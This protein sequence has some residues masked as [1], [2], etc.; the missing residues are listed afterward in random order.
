[1]RIITEKDKRGLLIAFRVF[2]RTMTGERISQQAGDVILGKALDEGLS[3]DVLLNPGNWARALE[4]N[5]E[6]TA[7][8]YIDILTE[9]KIDIRPLKEE[10]LWHIPE[11]GFTII[12]EAAHDFFMEVTGRGGKW[13]IPSALTNLAKCIQLHS[14]EA[15]L[16]E[17][18]MNRVCSK[19][20]DITYFGYILAI[21]KDFNSLSIETG[22]TEAEQ[23]RLA[24]KAGR[25]E[26]SPEEKKDNANKEEEPEEHQEPEVEEYLDPADDPYPEMGQEFQQGTFETSFIAQANP[27]DM[28][29][30]CLK[31]V[32]ENYT[33]Y[34]LMGLVQTVEGGETKTVSEIIDCLTDGNFDVTKE[35]ADARSIHQNISADLTPSFIDCVRLQ[36]V[37][38]DEAIASQYDILHDRWDLRTA[39]T[40][41]LH[42]LK[43]LILTY[44]IDDPDLNSAI[45]DIE[46][47][48]KDKEQ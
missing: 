44:G 5:P 28:K 3:F 22:P 8:D 11:K 24:A 17:E 9:G 47:L 46:E 15:I 33:P 45:G 34:E 29:R 19:S 6:P 2:M 35:S 38:M 25:K 32:L 21:L 18:L 48:Y 13:N 31:V 40:R 23:R 12:A 27:R 41:K 39:E 43:R 4:V 16:S 20:E 10:E 36:G 14:L 30:D 42:K 1:M 26:E 37:E 7:K